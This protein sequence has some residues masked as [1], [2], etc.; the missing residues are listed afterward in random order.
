MFTCERESDFSSLTLA[1]PFS[2]LNLE[3]AIGPVH[4]GG[5]RDF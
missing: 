4:A 1:R 2:L 3:T 5:G